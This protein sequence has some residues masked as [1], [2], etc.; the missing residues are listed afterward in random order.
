MR[1]INN[2]VVWLFLYIAII[3]I[4]SSIFIKKSVHSYA[5]YAVASRGLGFLFT[6]FTFFSTWISGATILGLATMSFKWG[7]DQ[8]WF[9][10][11]TYIMGA[12][13][14]PFFLL[15]IR[16][17]NVYTL[18]D[19][20]ALRYP[21]HEKGVRLLVALSQLCRNMSIIGAQLVTIA[22]V[23]SI[24]FGLDFNQTLFLTALFIV[25]YT[26]ISGLWGVAVSDVF[27]GLLQMVGIPLLIYQ[28]VR[29]AGG[30][31]NIVRFYQNIDGGAYLNIFASLGKPGEMLLLFV[32]PGLFFIV[33][34]QTTWQRINSSKSDKVAFWGY[35]A[36]LGAALLWL[37][38]PCCIGVFSKVIFPNFTAYPVAFLDFVLGLPPA[39][40]IIILVTILSA[41]VS[42]CDSYLLASGMIFSQDIVKK[43]FKPNISEQ[44]M[45][46]VTRLSIIAFGILDAA[47]GTQ[48]YDIFELYMLGAYIGGSVLTAPYFLT[49][50][51]KRMN[52]GGIIAGMLAGALT[53]YLGLR[54]FALS[55]QMAMLV[56]MLANVAIAYLACLLTKAPAA[57]A[58]RETY[59]FSPKFNSKKIKSIT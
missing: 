24:S 39:V 12:L 54:V 16:K 45:I 41:S 50:F 35:L 43:I 52:G 5:E 46:R 27:Q 9:I 29:F 18:G 55:Y 56:S 38:V 6:F 47:V 15:R 40:S 33:E 2:Y 10:A 30:I 25:L 51:S 21:G 32:A 13:S 19:F 28:V 20:F 59:Y 8:Y 4:C 48:I 11:V 22:F 3:L 44:A 1:A 37:L 57:E 53:F 23:V 26:T 34:D 36:P 42:T 58:I 14:G 31:E 49:W 17:L 7:M